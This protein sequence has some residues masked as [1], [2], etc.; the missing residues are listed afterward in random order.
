M[1]VDIWNEVVAAYIN[2]DV[3]NGL[4]DILLLLQC[5]I[6]YFVSD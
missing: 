6:N 1:S 4:T 2:F 3:T 5:I